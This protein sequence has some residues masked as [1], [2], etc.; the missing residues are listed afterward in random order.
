MNVMGSGASPWPCLLCD[1]PQAPA[2]CLGLFS[3][4][5]RTFS[6]LMVLVGPNVWKVDWSSLQ[7]LDEPNGQT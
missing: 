1:R 7:V 4:R 6:F 3:D 5:A 2:R